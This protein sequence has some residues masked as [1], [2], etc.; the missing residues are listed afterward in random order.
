MPQFKFEGF[1]QSGGRVSS[2]LE[3]ESAES[4]LK[5]LRARGILASRIRAVDPSSDWKAS[6]GLASDRVGLA[7]LEFMTAELSLLLESGVRIDRAIGILQR[8]GKSVAVSTLLTS[9]AK[10]LKQGKQLSEALAAHPEVFDKLYVNLVSLGEAGGRLPD[11]FRGLAEDLRFQ[12][13]LRQKVISAATYPIVVASVC[14]I[15]VLFIFNFVVPNLETLFS[16]ASELPWYTSMLLSSSEFMRQ[17]QWFVIGGVA[18]GAMSVW[19]MRTHPAVVDFRDRFLIDTPGIRDANSMVERI[20][21]SSGLA[22]MLDSGLPVDRALTLA[23][24]NIRHGVLRR[25]MMAAVEKVK[26]GEQLSAVLRQTR[27]FPDYYASLLEVGEESGRLGRVFAEIASRSRDTFSSW[28]L[29]LTTLLEPLLILIMG[30]IVGGVVVIMMLS[31]TS[32]TE[33]GL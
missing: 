9:I 20:R 12:R 5:E 3:S 10:E 23:T 14:V 7:D 2:T 26:R 18:I 22:L 15:A 6:L 8:S 24:G 19:R 21:F 33:V 1:D 32:V 11:V 16:D 4:A 28:T 30:L 29:R 17:W 27:L 31:I 13:D 25:E